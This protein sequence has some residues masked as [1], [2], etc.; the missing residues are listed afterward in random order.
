MNEYDVFDINNNEDLK[1]TKSTSENS[2]TTFNQTIIKPYQYQKDAVKKIRQF[3]K[4]KNNIRGQLSISCGCGKTLISFLIASKYKNIIIISPLKQFAE[5]NLMRYC[6]YDNEFISNSLL[7]DSDGIRD[8]TKI[9]NFIKKKKDKKI[10]FSSTYKSVDIVNQ[11]LSNLNLDDTIFIFD[12]FHNISIS[13]LT[14]PDDSI[15]QLL[16]SKQRILF[17][18]ATLRYYWYDW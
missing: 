4:D 12:E 3:F 8:F 11:I 9:N 6:E 2:N 5:Q 16:N 1:L 7:I 13:N 17:L 15:N 14:N 18:S 10:L